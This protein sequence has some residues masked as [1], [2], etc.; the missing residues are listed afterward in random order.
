MN[1]RRHQRVWPA[2]CLSEPAK[3]ERPAGRQVIEDQ[4]V[5]RRAQ[6]MTIDYSVPLHYQIDASGPD[7]EVTVDTKEKDRGEQERRRMS[8]DLLILSTTDI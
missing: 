5:R 3:Q 7:H 6:S 8:P 2:L 4:A 1:E